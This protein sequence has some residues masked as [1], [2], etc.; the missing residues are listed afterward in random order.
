LNVALLVFSIIVS[1]KRIE[2]ITTCRLS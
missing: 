2:R 1:A